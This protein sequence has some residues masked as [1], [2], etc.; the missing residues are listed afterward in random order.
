MRCPRC[1]FEESL[2]RGR[3]THC[4]YEIG[5]KPHVSY[6]L[7][8]SPTPYPNKPGLYVPMRGD[9]LGDG[10]Y[11]L[12]NQIALPE[13]QQKQG[14]AWSAVDSIT[15]QRQVVIREMLVPGEL[16]RGSS[17][18]TICDAVTQRLK[19][20]GQHVGFPAV[21]D[22]FKEKG[23][24]FI[25]F[26]YPEGVSLGSLLK[27]YGGALPEHQ[28]A[29]YGYQLCGL[30]S[31]LAEQQ[32]PLVHGSINPETIIVNEDQMSVAL[33]HLP[34]FQ[35]EPPPSS[36]GQVSAGYYAPEQIHG[37]TNLSTDLYGLAV[38]LHYIVTG[39]DPRTR[40]ALFHP[41]ARRLNPAVS[42]QIEAILARQLSLSTSQ[43]YTSPL[44]MQEDLAELIKS[45]TDTTDTNMAGREVDPLQISAMQLRDRSRSVVLLN[46]GVFAAICVL[47]LLGLF[48]AT[49]R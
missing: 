41:P 27:R 6:S 36:S 13:T 32:P 7:P 40:L 30:L 3:C 31:T 4:G 33:V 44:E 45:S 10:R 46:M 11:R 14:L 38:T 17:V 2:I 49:L 25:V 19:K 9:N 18:D 21:S 16:T 12:V 37:E 15:S 39:Y 23:S 5:G 8:A 26:L 28:A 35:P 20:L 48:F 47:L 1:G 34:L 42:P 29:E 22:F 43:R 24:Y